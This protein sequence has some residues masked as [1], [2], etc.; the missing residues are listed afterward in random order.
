MHEVYND[1]VVTGTICS[2]TDATTLHLANG[3]IA[4][5][6]ASRIT[7]EAGGAGSLGAI[8][9]RTAIQGSRT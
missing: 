9:G 2:A 7:R 4:S 6:R 5:D 1:A 8:D 3:Y